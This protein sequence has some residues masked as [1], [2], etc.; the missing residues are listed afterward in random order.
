MRKLF[1]VVIIFSLFLSSCN[2][3]SSTSST[4][5]AERD[6]P[7]FEQWKIPQTFVP[8]RIFVVGLGDSLTEGIG[9]ELK[10]GGYFS[11]VTTAMDDW[12]GVKEVEASNLAKKGRRSDQLIKQLENVEVQSALK[13][14]DVILFT[15]GGNDMMKIVKRDL[16]Q[17]KKQPFY[18]ELKKYESRLDEIFGIIRGLNADAI[19]VAGG[20][21][22]PLSIVTDEAPEFKT[23]IDDWNAAMEVRTVL[24]GKSCFVPVTDL[25][26]SNENLV[27]HTDFFHPNA[28]GY[29][30]MTNRYIESIDGCNLLKLSDGRLDM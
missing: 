19:I 1:V 23:I 11:R 26:D 8:R 4:P 9:D 24:D 27:Y 2:T 6:F 15:I 12:K 3:S 13:N 29:E 25:F 30:L 22:N 20:L 28:K 14:A 16:F 5:V 21:Y 7:A 17:L 10:R 18:D